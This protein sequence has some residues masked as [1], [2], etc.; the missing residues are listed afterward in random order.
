[1]NKQG[2]SNVIGVQAQVVVVG[3]GID[4]TATTGSDY[5][6]SAEVEQVAEQKNECEQA[7]CFNEIAR[8]D[9]IA[10]S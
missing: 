5:V 10:S 4:N 8:Q 3:I 9:Q 2:A 7:G 6:N 1:M